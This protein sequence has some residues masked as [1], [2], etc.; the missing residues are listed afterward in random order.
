MKNL[1]FVFID[2][3]MALVSLKNFD[4]YFKNS[5]IKGI[6]FQILNRIG[7]EYSE[8]GEDI[9]MKLVNY[10]FENNITDSMFFSSV[11]Y[12]SLEFIDYLFSLEHLS[13]FSDLSC[14]T[15]KV[16]LIL[17]LCYNS[18]LENIFRAFDKDYLSDII[19]YVLD[20]NDQETQN[21][22]KSLID[23]GLVE[24][25]QKKIF[26]SPVFHMELN[27]VSNNLTLPK[28]GSSKV[29]NFT[30]NTSD[31]FEREDEK[32]SVVDVKEFYSKYSPSSCQ[33]N[34]E[35]LQN[36]NNI[37]QKLTSTPVQ[38]IKVNNEMVEKFDD[39]L[40][41]HPNIVD[42]H[43]LSAIF[44]VC[45][46]FSKHNILRIP[47]LLFHGEPGT[48]KNHFLKQLTNLFDQNQILIP[49]GMGDGVGAIVGSAPTYRNSSYGQLL[50]S[51]WS[52]K[53]ELI[54]PNPLVCIDELDKG[55]FSSTSSDPHQN[56]LPTLLQLTG[57]ADKQMFKDNFFSVKLQKFHPNIIFTANDISQIPISLV[58][59]LFAIE[60]RAYTEKE[61]KEIVI[62]SKY[63][64]FKQ[65]LNEN[66][67]QTLSQQDTEIIFQLCDG[68]T[69]KL[70]IAF[71]IF[72]A[73]SFDHNGKK[74]KC[75]FDKY[76]KKNIQQTQVGF[77]TNF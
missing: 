7:L 50:A 66:V 2:I 46:Y 18:I 71:N 27:R 59:R 25:K 9:L 38:Y 69:R 22:L 75:N 21:V 31:W 8:V 37:F 15:K 54:T 70:Q 33:L 32:L 51:L 53:D 30:F 56:I 60:F 55:V 72:L 73:E 47:P 68:Q 77:N 10:N 76:L 62:P 20:I 43:I 49:V 61:F 34:P 5:K 4:F 19:K 58:D 3:M 26:L 29:N 24:K 44:K 57:E 45:F 14:Q 52:A 39:I 35:T 64:E 40:E 23:T 11:E 41:E 28:V 1:R 6:I 67:P 74:E 13:L 42:R 17:D 36:I 48:G 12:K 63:K 16:L 65:N